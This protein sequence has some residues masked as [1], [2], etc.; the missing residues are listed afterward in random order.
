[1]SDRLERRRHGA[2]KKDILAILL[3]A[4]EPLTATQVRERLD[5]AVPLLASVLTVLDRLRRSG[6]I[7][8]VEGDDGQL[9]FA[10]ARE[11]ASEV[12]HGMLDNLLRSSDR[13]GAL[14]SFAGSL[15]ADD[16]ETLRRALESS[17]GKNRS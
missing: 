8:R 4:D 6:E 14:L 9:R 16:V 5:G 2:L 13:A 11:D 15:R 17:R 3:H 10:I 12:A 1:M 7:A